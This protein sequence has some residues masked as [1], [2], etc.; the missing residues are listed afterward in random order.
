MRWAEALTPW[1]VLPVSDFVTRARELGGLMWRKAR[2]GGEA[3]AEALEQQ[4]AIQRLAGQV[5]KLDRDRRGLYSDI[6]TKVYALHRQGKVRNQDVLADCDR[7]DEVLADIA[8]LR[9][10]IDEVRTANLAKGVRIAEL[11]DVSALTEEP[12]AEAA[13]ACAAPTSGAAHV[14]VSEADADDYERPDVEVAP[15]VYGAEDDEVAGPP[16]GGD[17]EAGTDGCESPDQGSAPDAGAAGEPD[18]GSE[19]GQ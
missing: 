8:K 15:R 13:P 17:V 10:E 11:E 3:A 6:G 19:K 12:E 14:S 16:A 18:A 2:Q 5:R 1:E 4:A 7:L 9:L